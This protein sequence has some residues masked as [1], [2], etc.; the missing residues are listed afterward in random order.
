ML[1]IAVLVLGSF[2]ILSGVQA[3]E[4]PA[5]NPDRPHAAGTLASP[6][7]EA[8]PVAVERIAASTKKKP[9][10]CPDGLTRNSNTGKCFNPCSHND[11]WENGTCVPCKPGSHEETQADDNGEEQ[12]VCVENVRKKE[13]KSKKCPQGTEFKNGKCRKT[14]FPPIEECPDGQN[15]DPVTG[16]CFSCSHNDHFENG[17]CVP[18]KQGFHVEGDA[19][20]SD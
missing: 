13:T 5:T 18:C 8:A 15:P 9:K 11:H 19:C 10:K 1:R 20:V 12:R 6:L 3:K 17:V 14:E 2:F 4:A 16:V 7:L